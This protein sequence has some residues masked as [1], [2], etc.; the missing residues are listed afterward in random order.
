MF[1]PDLNYSVSKQSTKPRIKIN[2]KLFNI[3]V[4]H[5]A[6]YFFNGKGHYFAFSSLKL[7]KCLILTES[8]KQNPVKLLL[9]GIRIL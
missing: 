4:V 7:N 5:I 1:K 8:S 6:L 9:K 3:M 2:S